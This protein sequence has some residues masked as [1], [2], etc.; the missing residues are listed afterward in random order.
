MLSNELF[1][2]NSII[3]NLFYLATFRAFCVNIGFSLLEKD[4]K[5]ADIAKSFIDE[6]DNLVEVVIKYADGNIPK[7]VL[8]S[9]ILITKHTLG[10]EQLTEKLFGVDLYT[11]ITKKEMKIIPGF[12]TNV[13]NEEVE[14]LMDINK[15][16]FFLCQKFIDYLKDLF[17]K[18]IK[19]QIFSY[20]YPFLTKK[21]MESI[22]LYADL[23]ER[24]INKINIDPTFIINYEYK[25]C[26]LMA[27]FGEF[28]RDF[29][30]P[31]RKDLFIKAQSFVVEFQLLNDMHAHNNFTPG[32]Q[33]KL[34]QKTIKIISRFADFVS[35]VI[36]SVLKQEAY[37]VVSPI[38][39]DDLYR[40]INYYKYTLEISQQQ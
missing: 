33:K 35:Y 25:A 16:A 40:A 10:C 37:L 22:K 18:Q 4:K 29:L 15:K 1:L 31:A 23:L 32:E 8:D 7:E 19:N 14:V 12:P 27:S 9:D 30:D 20:T 13:N 17:E 28:I 38:F 2:S 6:C 34:I 36:E 24:L 21:M 5:Y 3:T 26:N 11:E 39:I